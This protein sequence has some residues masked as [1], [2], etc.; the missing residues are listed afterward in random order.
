[1]SRTPGR[2]DGASTNRHAMSGHRIGTAAVKASAVSR[3]GCWW[4]VVGIVPGLMACSSSA[5]SSSSADASLDSGGSTALDG[6]ASA[7]A[8]VVTG[9]ITGGST[10]KPFTAAPLDLASYGYVEQ[11]YFFAGTATA[12]DWVTPPTARRRLV[13]QAD[14]DGQLRD[15][16]AGPSPDRPGEVQRDGDRRVAQ[17][18][19]RRRCRPRVRLRARRAPEERVRLRRGLRPGGRASWGERCRSAR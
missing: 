9:P 10:G 2:R 12:Y 19:G 16:H 5:A 8:P 6:G 17:R 7:A 15:A 13:G 18:H 11:E 4:V 3:P 14:D 1:M